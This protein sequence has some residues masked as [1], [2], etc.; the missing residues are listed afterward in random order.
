LFVSIDAYS[1]LL[2]V[3]FL[4]Y[5]FPVA[6]PYGKTKKVRWSEE[7]KNT[8]LEAFAKHMKNCTLPSLKEIQN[9]KKK[10]KALSQ[11]TSP[12]IK[13]W[14][15]NKQKLMQKLCKLPYTY[16]F[17]FVFLLHLTEEF[18]DYLPNYCMKY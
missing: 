8:V 10:Y 9:T 12:Q 11:R 5:Y 6:S 3:L 13:T 14:I 4:K 17:S 7:E 18:S 2:Y 16:K 1:L 15:H